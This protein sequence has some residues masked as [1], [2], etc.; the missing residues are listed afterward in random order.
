MYC[1]DL[2]KYL[3]ESN[4]LNEFRFTDI[5]EKYGRLCIYN[6]GEPDSAMF[7][8]ALYERFS[9]QVCLKYGKL[10]SY[11]TKGWIMPICKEC[12]TSVDILSTEIERICNTKTMSVSIYTNSKLNYVKISLRPLI[13]EY[14]KVLE[15][16]DEEFIT[17]VATI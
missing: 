12:T 1:K 10:A 14:K 2:R 13:R 17:Y 7:L 5:K 16:S 11:T 3:V 4:V 8:T 15:M 6:A 9:E